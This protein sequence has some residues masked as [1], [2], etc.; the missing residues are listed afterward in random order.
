MP[1][2][3]CTAARDADTG[4]SKSTSDDRTHRARRQAAMRGTH[5]EEHLAAVA[6]VRISPIV[7]T[8]TAAW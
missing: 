2:D 1:E 6:W 4:T 3:V 5:A 8:E 7:N